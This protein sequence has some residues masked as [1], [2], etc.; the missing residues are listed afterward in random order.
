MI[1]Y[2]VNSSLPDVDSTA[3]V[4]R[5]WDEICQLLPII[6]LDSVSKIHPDQKI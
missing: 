5:R 3:V 4:S 1:L 6:A 2:Q